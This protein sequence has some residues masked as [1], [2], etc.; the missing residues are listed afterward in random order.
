MSEG[1]VCRLLGLDRSSYR[2][3]PRPNDN[4][5]LCARL[6]ELAVQPPRYGY[7]RLGALPRREG[8]QVNHKKVERLYRQQGL[9][10]ERANQLWSLD[11]VSDTTAQ[12]RGLRLLTVVDPY[13]RECL[14]IETDTSLTA[15]RVTAALERVLDERE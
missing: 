1:R 7:H 9:A 14:A 15:R 4:Q 11:F 2:Y 5:E 10:L 3:R 6:R 13:T 12:G 8:R